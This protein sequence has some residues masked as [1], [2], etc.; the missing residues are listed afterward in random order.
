MRLRL[1][2]FDILQDSEDLVQE[3]LAAPN[4]RPAIG[5]TIGD[6]T[7]EDEAYVTASDAT[8][9]CKSF[10]ATFDRPYYA[11]STAGHAEL[12]NVSAATGSASC[13][14]LPRLTLKKGEAYVSAATRTTSCEEHARLTL[15][16]PH[17]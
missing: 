12:G 16:F 4:D 10:L 1:P 9:Q 11:V 15:P 14:E 8:N 6:T 7:G 2:D 13:E 3:Q 17:R 5:P